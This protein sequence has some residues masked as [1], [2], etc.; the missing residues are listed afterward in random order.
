MH[1]VCFLFFFFHFFSF[2]SVWPPRPLLAGHTPSLFLFLSISNNTELSMGVTCK[3]P[4]SYTSIISFRKTW[5]NASPED[6]SYRH[7]SIYSL[8]SKICLMRLKN[9]LTQT[10]KHCSK[11]NF[12]FFIYTH[13]AQRENRFW[14]IS[15]DCRCNLIG[16]F[17]C[18]VWGGVPAKSRMS[19]KNLFGP[20]EGNKE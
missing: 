5:K 18:R 7:P 13:D 4:A 6:K 19:C 14:S 3:Y 16:I 12:F 11:C 9:V 2:S 15:S 20:A 1:F 17:I 10:H 8:F